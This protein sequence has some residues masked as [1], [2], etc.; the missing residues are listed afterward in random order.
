MVTVVPITSNTDRLFQFQLLLPVDESGLDRD[1]KAQ[2]EQVRAVSVE[3]VSDKL[4]TVPASLMADVDETLRLH[5]A[6]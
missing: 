4:G 3:R 1:S 6:L 5:V 2:A